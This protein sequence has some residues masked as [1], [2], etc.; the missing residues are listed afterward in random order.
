MKTANY[1]P[2]LANHYASTKSLNIR[3]KH[4]LKGYAIYLIMF[5]KLAATETRSIKMDQIE[6][7]AFELHLE[8]KEE[9][10]IEIIRTYFNINGEE[11]YSQELNDSLAWYDEKYNKASQGG[12][13]AAENMTPEQRKERSR[14]ANE[15]KIKKKNLSSSD[16]P[17]KE[18]TPNQLSDTLVKDIISQGSLPNNKIEQNKR[19]EKRTESNGREVKEP[20]DKNI[21]SASFFTPFEVEDSI[22]KYFSEPSM[23]FFGDNQNVVINTYTNYFKQYQQTKLT[24]SKFEKILYFHLS[25]M[26]MSLN[27]KDLNEYIFTHPISISIEDV[28]NTVKLICDNP[29]VEA[30]FKNI[31]EEVNL[32]S[33]DNK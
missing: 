29:K 10:L 33:N 8:Q 1:F 12:K 30:G 9:E 2:L 21:E 23:F 11:F 19:E 13:K 7:L 28:H 15:E 27:V 16:L 14:T 26:T 17:R 32:S 5:Q 25:Q 22:E 3:R 4:G 6:E 18:N 20:K 24:L 31:I